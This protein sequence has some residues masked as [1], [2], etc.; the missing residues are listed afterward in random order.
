MR[1]KIEQAHSGAWLLTPQSGKFCGKVVAIADGI[2]MRN[3]TFEGA[4]IY[5]EARA[6]YGLMP[7]G[8]LIFLDPDTIKGLGLGGNFNMRD[9]NVLEFSGGEYVLTDTGFHIESAL[10]LW[11]LKD[12]MQ[13]YGCAE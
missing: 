5:G 13:A 1:I 3:V 4:Y 10:S 2:S 11:V 12:E 6:V 9:G 8:G 7:M